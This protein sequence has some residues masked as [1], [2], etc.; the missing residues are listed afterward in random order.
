MNNHINLVVKDTDYRHGDGQ[1]KLSGITT[2][3]WLSH[4]DFFVPQFLSNGDTDDC[5][6]FGATK[7]VDAFMDAL[8]ADN[9]L[10]ASVVSQLTTWGFM[11]TGTDGKP[12]FHSSE[13]FAGVLSGLG[14]NGGNVSTAYD[15]FRKYG[16]VPFTLLPVTATMTLDEYF[17]PIPQNIIDIGAQ[18]LALMGGKNFLQ[19][20]W[21]NDGGTTNVPKM[22]ACQSA[23][24][25]SLGIPVNDAGWN[26]V[27]PTIATGAPVH[28]VSGGSVDLP[29]LSVN[30][31]DNYAPFLKVLDRG[32]QISYVLQI[33]VQYIPPP[34]PPPP[35][36]PTLPTNPTIPQVQNW[37]T[38][39]L[40]WLNIIK[41]ENLTSNMKLKVY[42]L[43]PVEQSFLD[44]AI[45]AGVFLGL[46]VLNYVSSLLSGGTI[47]LPYAA[48]SLPV[49][50]LI[51]SQLDSKF[52]AWSQEFDVPLPPAAPT[53]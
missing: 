37:L 7:N 50:T 28:V 15:I 10:P 38:K 3:N 12:H 36:A 52:V 31:S 17:A 49:L 30:I 45:K 20:Q 11:D 33:V 4:F 42:S 48:V 39:L 24:P 1:L 35:P 29:T 43:S 40:I 34:P 16:V 44:I 46:L 25:Y 13:R 19:Y 47:Q 51:V 5:W 6:D 27:H 9:L 53:A 14:T 23:G 8:I 18:F 32:Y 26:Q 41:A 22:A 2:T 21:I